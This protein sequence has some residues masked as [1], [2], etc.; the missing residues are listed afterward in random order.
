MIAAASAPGM[1]QKTIN[2]GSGTETSVRELVDLVLEVTGGKPE[3]VNN[4]RNEGGVRRMR[5]DL[6]Q[7]KQ[8]LGYHPAID[9]KTGLRLTLENDKLLKKR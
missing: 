3:I 9:L 7:A 6:T 5:A 4:P 1:N 2:I 8:L